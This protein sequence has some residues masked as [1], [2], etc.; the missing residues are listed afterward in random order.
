MK[1]IREYNNFKNEHRTPI[2][3]F[4]EICNLSSIINL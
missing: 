4:I 3:N 1:H 2:D